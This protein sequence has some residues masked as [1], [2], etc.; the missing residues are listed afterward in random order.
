ME[1][2]LLAAGCFW[3]VEE[4]FRTTNGIIDTKVGYSGGHKI[5]PTY[6]E[7]CTGNTD[8][9][10]VVKV[11]YDESVITYDQILNIFFENH[12]PTQLNRQG[13]D[14]GTQYRSSIFYLN[15]N[16]KSQAEQKINSLQGNFNNNIVTEIKKATEFYLAEEYHQE[17]VAK[18]GICHF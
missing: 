14:V 9:A 2:A 18:G 12:N 11:E 16:Q 6:E 8:H 1:K 17:Y 13:P 5:N 3:G 7:V 15:N 10:E 4:V